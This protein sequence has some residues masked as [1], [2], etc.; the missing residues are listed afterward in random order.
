MLW[1][2][3]FHSVCQGAWWRYKIQQCHCFIAPI[4]HTSCSQPSPVGSSHHYLMETSDSQYLHKSC[5]LSHLAFLINFNKYKCYNRWKLLCSKR[6]KVSFQKCREKSV[7]ERKQFTS[8]MTD[9]HLQGVTLCSSKV[10]RE[11]GSAD[12]WTEKCK[13]ERR[14]LQKNWRNSEDLQKK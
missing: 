8:V 12:E 13:T 7:F 3:C 5:S 1:I 6:Y 9:I 2:L 14:K 11:I 4:A 10:V